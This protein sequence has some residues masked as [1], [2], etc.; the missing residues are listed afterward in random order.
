MIGTRHLF[1]FPGTSCWLRLKPLITVPAR[2]SSSGL[3]RQ[4]VRVP[5]DRSALG[6][7][8]YSQIAGFDRYANAA[9]LTLSNAIYLKVGGY[10]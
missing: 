7:V 4:L 1:L 9:G 8:L 2:F 10:R 3:F 6:A 5:N